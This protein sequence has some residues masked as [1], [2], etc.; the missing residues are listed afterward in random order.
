MQAEKIPGEPAFR[1][2]EE[3]PETGR[4]AERKRS[5]DCL[6][7]KTHHCRKRFACHSASLSAG[8]GAVGGAAC[9][10]ETA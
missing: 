10:A 1:K 5:D 4:K 2:S 9:S 6:C 3:K 7:G 8:G